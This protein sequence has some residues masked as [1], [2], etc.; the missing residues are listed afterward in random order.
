MKPP[1]PTER[2]TQ[3][4]ILSMMGKCF[5]QVFVAHIPNGA[6]LAGSSLARAK[7]IGAL[8]G[9]GMKVGMPDLLCLW[10]GGGVLLEVKREKG[11]V[12]SDS[13]KA[14]HQRL[15]DIGWPVS[16]VRCEGEA[17]GALVDAGAPYAG[18]LA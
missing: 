15:S 2:A 10:D 12:V 17:W 8:K 6:H 3:R 9:D 13:Q 11:G 18:V 1:I 4:S 16:I 5:P 14:V 7:Q